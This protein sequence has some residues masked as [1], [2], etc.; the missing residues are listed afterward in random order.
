MIYHH[1]GRQLCAVSA[2]IQYQIT[3]N[4]FSCETMFPLAQKGGNAFY[5]FVRNKKLRM[6][7]FCVANGEYSPLPNSRTSLM[8]LL[9]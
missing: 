2:I 8:Y 1:L 4:I 3:F 9:T 7:G 5:S 6:L